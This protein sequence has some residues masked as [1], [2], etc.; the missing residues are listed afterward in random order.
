VDPLPP[1]QS[2]RWR[3]VAPA[4]VALLALT[5]A[6]LFLGRAVLFRDTWLWVVPARALVRDAL[7]S[8]RLPRWNPFVGL[9][10][11]VPAEPLY[12]LYY[13]PHLATVLLADVA[14]GASLD[15]WLH[16]LLG[17]LGAAALAAR[18]GARTTGAIVAGIAWSLAGPV[19]SEWGAGARLFGLAWLPWCALAAWDLAAAPPGPAWRRAALAA[20]L[21]LGMALLAGEPFVALLGALFGAALSLAAVGRDRWPR[22]LAGHALA[23]VGAALLA[24][25]TLA[26][27]VRGA[28]SSQRAH[29]LSRALAEQLSMHPWRLVDLGSLGGLGMAW[30][31]RVDPAVNALLDPHPL[32]DSLYLGAAALALAALGLGRAR[33]RVALAALAVAGVLLALGRHT[34]VH[35]VFRR[36]VVPFL[37]M[38]S[39][40]KYVAVAAAAV[41]LLA[42]L[43]ADRLLAD[44]RAALRAAGALAAVHL[45]LWFTARAW[46]PRGL[47]MMIPQG[48][49]IGLLAAA[50]L[51]LAAALARRSPRAAAAVVVAAVALD[52]GENARRFSRWGDGAA[53][54]RAP[55]AAA[56]V[57]A[58]A[59]PHAVARL[60]RSDAFDRVPRAGDRLA[61]GRATLQ[62]N[63]G[64]LFGVA[65]LPGYDVGVSPEVD[66]LLAR[67]RI[68]ALRVLSV[69]AALMPTRAGGPPPGL[70]VVTE[71]APGA[72]LYRVLDTLPRAYVAS[73]AVAMSI[74]QARAHLLDPEVVHGRR[75]LLSSPLPTS[76]APSQTWEGVG[77]RAP[78]A[79]CRPIGHTDGDY[80]VDCD[81][82]EGGWAVFIEQSTPGWGATVDG[83]DAGPI[84]QANVVGMAVR[85]AS[86]PRTQRVRLAFT[87]PG[88]RAGVVLGALAWS[89]LAVGWWVSSRARARSEAHPP[90]G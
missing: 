10:F 16:L 44:R 8:G 84:R 20:A 32:L 77:G 12:G 72:T 52:L 18:L 46:M 38:R 53:A 2:A 33:A 19:Q 50:L 47:A 73:D 43:G 21:P 25:P 40:E 6:P 3:V 35:A 61:F 56:A 39:P 55:A 60:Y 41:A 63:T 15:A 49:V 79:A 36:V 85:L 74:E 4:L 70:E 1:P 42:G 22:A 65:T 76:E 34:P 23:A 27:M 59:P 58:L 11:S 26:P 68:D 69:D 24:A 64:A 30:S 89:A 17:A 87:P 37:Y 80:T 31:M 29:G 75:V 90:P 9:G 71:V 88:E 51:A 7:L 28:A 86:S 14:W 45:A 67:R 66:D 78:L 57:R 82:P 83:R 54:L 5:H 48:A 62:P 81:A 13:P